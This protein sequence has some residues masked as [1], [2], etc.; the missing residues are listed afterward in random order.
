VPLDEGWEEFVITRGTSE[1]E[2]T[3]TTNWTNHTYPFDTLPLLESHLHPKFVIFNSGKKING[4]PV[5]KYTKLMQQFP[6]LG[7]V[8][9][10]YMAWLES[11]PNTVDDTSYNHDAPVDS[12]D[13]D[14]DD[15][16]MVPNGSE[17]SDSV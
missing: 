8:E 15:V 14:D 2:H 9:N 3:E 5:H 17:F 7:H 4:L 11:L 16:T 1:D 12:V 10:L 6:I 13:S